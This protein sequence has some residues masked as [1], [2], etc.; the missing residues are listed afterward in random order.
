MWDQRL[1]IDI[2]FYMD[3]EGEAVWSDSCMFPHSDRRRSEEGLIV[4]RPNRRIRVTWV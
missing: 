3:N 1:G 2:Y 4:Y